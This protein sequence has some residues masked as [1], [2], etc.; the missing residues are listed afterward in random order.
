MNSVLIVD[1]NVAFRRVL[2]RI[3]ERDGYLTLEANDGVEAFAL[4]R[5]QRPDVLL[6]DRHMPGM[7]GLEV[8]NL[9]RVGREMED[10]IIVCTGG[11]AT[12]IPSTYTILHKPVDVGVL[13]RAVAAKLRSPRSKQLAAEMAHRLL[14]VELARLLDCEPTDDDVVKSTALLVLATPRH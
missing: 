6:L 9:L 13:L 8:L 4:M 2:V 11:N 14:L 3:L 12:E 1:D 5:A 7:D 10:R